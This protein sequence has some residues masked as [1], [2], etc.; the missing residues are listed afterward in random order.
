MSCLLHYR[1]CVIVCLNIYNDVL[2]LSALISQS[3]FFLETL[4][5][6]Q[7]VKKF[8]AFLYEIRRV[9]HWPVFRLS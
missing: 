8:P 2:L 7:Q 1:N 5:L 6:H 9:R 3:R 4:I